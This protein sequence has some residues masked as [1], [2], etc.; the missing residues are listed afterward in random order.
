M[1]SANPK[2][3]N[4]CPK[5]EKKVRDKKQPLRKNKAQ[6][7]M[8]MYLEIW[9]ERPHVSEVSGKVIPSFDVSCFMHV[10]N[11]NTYSSLKLDKRNVF[12]VLK[13]EHHHYDNIGRDDLE[14]L[15]EWEKVFKRHDELM[16]ECSKGRILYRKS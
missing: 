6:G 9:L 2:S 14:L 10:L 11:K 12:L 1:F 13:E 7:Y 15:P 4:P 3:F 8:K 16:L 5:P